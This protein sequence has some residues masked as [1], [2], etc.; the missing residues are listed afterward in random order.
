MSKRSALNAPSKNRIARVL[1]GAATALVFSPLVLALEVR[2]PQMAGSFYPA[3]PSQLSSEIDLLLAGVSIDP[4]QGDLFAL[5]A[6]HAGIV[7]SGRVAAHG[8]KL[9]KDKEI[10]T[11]VLIGPSHRI[12]FRGAS[13][14]QGGSWKTPLGEI[15]IDEGLAQAIAGES[16]DLQYSSEVHIPEHSLEVQ[17][18]FLQRVLENFKIVPILVGDLSLTTSNTLARALDQHVRGKKV[19]IVASTDMSHYHASK[20]AET[21]DQHT[22]DLIKS[23]DSVSLFSELQAG[24]SELCGAAAVLTLLDLLKLR[25]IKDIQGL[26]YAH[27]GH[28]TGD[29][30]R[31][32]GYSAFA[33]YHPSAGN[34]TRSGEAEK[35]M[36]DQLNSEQ[37]TWLL[38][39]ARNTL[40]TF[41]TQ[42]KTVTPEAAD[43]RLK[44]TQAAFVTLH[45]EGELRGCIGHILPVE[46]LYLSI[47]NNAISAATQ[48]PRFPPVTSDELQDLEIE[49][50]VL[51]VPRRIFDVGEIVMGEH[52]VILKREGRSG[53][54]LPKVATETGWTKERFLSELCSQKAGL[55]GD[56]WKDPATE[57]YIFGT[58]DFGEK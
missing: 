16:P 34:A 9:L 52:G 6:P 5:I 35:E 13:V 1:L 28:A 37:K 7:Y 38:K 45:K 42:G 46:P 31:V 57:V 47:R 51:E 56:C 40:T 30:S 18:P 48:D 33:I 44:E 14:W 43:S 27:S 17:L 21:M 26:K 24:R 49:I 4:P 20:E 10:E 54:F 25:G 12:P 19:L 32:V 29:V 2:E 50:S 3:N 23:L 22:L 58:Q 36:Q 15:P 55:R 39:L 53:V 11:V 41:V 8:Y